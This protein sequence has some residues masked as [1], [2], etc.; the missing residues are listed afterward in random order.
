MPTLAWLT[1]VPIPL[2]SMGVA[3]Q[4]GLNVA[5]DDAPFDAGAAYYNARQISLVLKSNVPD[6][7]SGLHEY[8]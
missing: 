4:A 3:I 7:A 1:G 6:Y 5:A 8:F 2:T